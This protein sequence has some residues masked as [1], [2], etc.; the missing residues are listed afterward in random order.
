MTMVTWC[1]A[2]GR[3]VQKSQL[4]SAD[5]RLVPGSRLTA[6]LRSGNLWGSRMKKTGVL[7]P[8]MSRLPSSVYMRTAKPRISRSASAAP[9]SPATVEKRMNRSVSLPTPLKTAALVYWLMSLVT[10]NLPKAPEPLACI[11]RS[12]ITSR[13]KWASFSR[14]QTSWRSIGPRGPAVAALSLS[15]TGAP[16]AVVTGLVLSVVIFPCFLVVDQNFELLKTSAHSLLRGGA[17]VGAQAPIRDFDIVDFET[18]FITRAQ[19][20]SGAGIIDIMNSP[21]FA[22]NYVLVVVPGV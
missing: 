12:G 4:F 7:L 1:S 20:S 9:R 5:R 17:T 19:G 15:A 21:T 8:T 11:R 10:V 2:S 14:N 22:A 3:L 6:R 16:A 18:V 13:S